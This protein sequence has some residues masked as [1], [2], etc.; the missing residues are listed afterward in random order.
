MRG[1]FQ[2]HRSSLQQR[3]APSHTYDL[4][5]CPASGLQVSA[6][7]ASCVRKVSRGS[8][9]NTTRLASGRASRLSRDN[10][11]CRRAKQLKLA[12]RSAATLSKTNQATDKASIPKALE[13]YTAHVSL[14]GPKQPVDV[15]ILGA[16]HVSRQSCTHITQLIS[17]MKPDIVLLELCKDRVDLLVDPSMPPPQ[18]WH[19]RVINFHSNFPQQ[20][21][22]TATACKKLLSQLRCQPGRSFAAFDIEQDCTQLLSSGLFASVA[23]VTQPALLAD[24]PMFVHDGSQVRPLL[25]RRV[26]TAARYLHTAVLLAQL[27]GW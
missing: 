15:Y 2:P 6:V 25:G 7:D 20:S 5:L 16:S 19:S 24:A 22:F 26:T 21:S 11:S 4:H 1:A 18:H 27:C 17:T 23:P 3:T 8:Q 14:Q 12:I 9:W 13:K 10:L